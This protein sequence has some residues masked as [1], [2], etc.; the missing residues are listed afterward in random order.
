VVVLSALSH[1]T[2]V[3]H[4]LAGSEL[5]FGLQ[6]LLNTVPPGHRVSFVLSPLA[7]ASGDGRAGEHAG[8]IASAF[9]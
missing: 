5:R 9:L 7:E 1:F 8:K 6:G 3:E 2:T 4:G